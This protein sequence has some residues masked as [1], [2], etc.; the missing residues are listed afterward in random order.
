MCCFSGPVEHVTSTRIFARRAENGRQVLAYQ[1]QY[2]S[3]RPVAMILPLPTA[4]G[5]P[6]AAA[7]E[8]LVTFINL[9]GYPEFFAHME[10]AFPAPR[11]L[12]SSFAAKSEEIS[13]TATVLPVQT[14]GDFVASFVPTVAD[15]R[16]LD[17]QFVLPPQ[18][19]SKIP[20]YHD[21]GFAVFQLK[22]AQN[23]KILHP[24]AFSFASRYSNKL[25]FPTVHIHDGQVHASEDFDHDLFW[26]P[27][28]VPRFWG[29]FPAR[30]PVP[31]D[32][33]YVRNSA[34]VM[35]KF[36]NPVKAKGLIARTGAGLKARLSG[37]LQNRDTFIADGA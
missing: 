9:K 37:T 13:V 5:R 28:P 12:F 23:G 24:M 21:Y 27:Q 19:W 22:A 2:A 29:L 34:D 32:A 18:T 8:P 6:S 25:F 30:Q 31:C 3:R 10:T 26:Q 1:M 4:L 14:V 16:R 15:F 36:V 20:A 35:G 7:A 33:E 11:P 17:K